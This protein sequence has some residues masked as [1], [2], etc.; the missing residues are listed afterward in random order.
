MSEEVGGVALFPAL[1]EAELRIGLLAGFVSPW[2]VERFRRRRGVS[3]SRP[4]W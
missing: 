1:G 4:R 3:V 2:A